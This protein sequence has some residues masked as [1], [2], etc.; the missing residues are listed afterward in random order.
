MYGFD[1]GFQYNFYRSYTVY[2]SGAYVRGKDLYNHS[3]LPQIPP[4]NGKV[5]IKTSEAKYIDIDLSA[6]IFDKQSKI[7]AGETATPGYAYFDLY[8]SSIPFEFGFMK[9]QIFGGIEN[10]SD[11]AYKNHLST[12]R[13]L[14][15]IEPGRNYFARIS[16]NW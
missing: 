3:D 4:L 14:I 6:T 9:Y 13:G 2:I 11:K 16:V 10:L 8:L 15:T 7:A 1:L 12:N 5:G